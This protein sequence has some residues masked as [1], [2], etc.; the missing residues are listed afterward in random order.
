MTLRKFIE[1]V[2]S[3][4]A[5]LVLELGDWLYETFSPAVDYVEEKTAQINP[6]A[7]TQLAILFILVVM[8]VLG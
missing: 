3:N 5:D 7:L 4:C 1:T 6:F 8:V 2:L